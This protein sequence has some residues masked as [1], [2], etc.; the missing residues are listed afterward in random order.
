MDVK[1]QTLND[2][3]NQPIRYVVPDYQREYVWDLHEQWEPLWTDVLNVAEQFVGPRRRRKGTVRVR[4]HFMGSIVLRPQ[5]DPSTRIPTVALVDG[6]QRL[7]TLQLILDAAQQECEKRHPDTAE[8][9]SALVLQRPEDRDARGGDLDFKIWPADPDDQMAF[10]Q[11]MRKYLPTT[12]REKERITAAH[13]WFVDQMEEWFEEPPKSTKSR[14]EALYQALAGHLQITV[15]ELGV[16]DD[17]Q[18]IFETLNSR[19]TP[20]KMFDLA[21]NF[22]LHQAS[23]QELDAKRFQR[24]YLREFAGRWWEQKTGSGHQRRSHVEAFLHHWLT[25][26]TAEEISPTRTFSAFREHVSDARGGQ[27]VGV[28]KDL[29]KFG[30]MYRDLQESDVSLSSGDKLSRRFSDFV[31]RWKVL[32]ADVFTPLILWLWGA[33]VSDQRLIKSLGSLES[34]MIRRLICGFGTRGHGS[35]ARKLLYEV[36][37]AP[38]TKVDQV[39]RE[40]LSALDSPRFEWPSDGEVVERLETRK[41]LG[42]ASVARTRM[43]LEAI[44]AEFKWSPYREGGHELATKKLTVEHI[45]PEKWAASPADWPAPKPSLAEPRKTAEQVRNTLVQSIGNLTLVPPTLNRRLGASG[46]TRKCLLYQQ[47]DKEGLALN[48]DLTHPDR[49]TA[50][51]VWDEEQIKKRSER[52]AARV[53]KIW[54]RPS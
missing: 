53:I 31:R 16:D 3:F 26:E 45:M 17:E 38:K 7:L 22:L 18:M 20:L 47:D 21:K 28:A 41:L 27:V 8:K 48:R 49:R 19:G 12:E 10:R 9:L 24:E 23:L 30:H 50:P 40:H 29:Q 6:Q 42:T 11:A 25:M 44:E 51:L 46:W 39:I 36:K 15:I 54:P 37:R 14:A 52:L 35:V 32:Q 1:L 13:S 43:V 5:R 4:S 33:G 2:L 34:Y